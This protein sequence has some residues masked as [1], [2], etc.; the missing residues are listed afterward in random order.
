M[1]VAV[2]RMDDSPGQVERAARYDRRVRLIPLSA[3]PDR[4]CLEALVERVDFHRRQ[5]AQTSRAQAEELG[6]NAGTLTHW[7]KGRRPLPD[8]AI[9]RLLAKHPDLRVLV[10]KAEQERVALRYQKLEDEARTRRA[11]G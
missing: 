8:D 7:R 2:E 11:G 4:P 9:V 10:R 6:V 1:A 5:D 3:H